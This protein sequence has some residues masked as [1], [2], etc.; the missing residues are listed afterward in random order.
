MQEKVEHIKSDVIKNF[1]FNK[2]IP[3]EDLGGGVTRQVLAHNQNLMV[4][5]VNFEK[6]S[7]GSLHHHPHEQISYI[8]DGEF[9]FS[10]GGH[11]EILRTGDTTYK[12]PDIEHGAVCLEKGSVLDIFT[13]M[14]KD[15]LGGE[16]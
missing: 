10:I 5:K 12:Q 8:L 4:V 9:E 3:L 11:K 15:F 7:V 16:Q 14:R 2:E 1:F 13:P 6:G